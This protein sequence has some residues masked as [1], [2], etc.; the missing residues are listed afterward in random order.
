MGINK[1]VVN[2]E[3]K[4]DLTADTVSPST[5]ASGITA[6]DKSG[7][8]IVGTFDTAWAPTDNELK[9]I[10]NL[11]Y[12]DY[13]GKMDWFLTKYGNRIKFGWTTGN[14]G[15]PS[16]A[17][18]YYP[19]TDLSRT[20][21]SC[22]LETLPIEKIYWRLNHTNENPRFATDSLFQATFKNCVNLK[23]LPIFE[24]VSIGSSPLYSHYY[25]G[26][27]FE[28]CEQLREI[29]F[30]DQLPSNKNMGHIRHHYDDVFAYCYSL[31]T[32]PSL[33]FL[34]CPNPDYGELFLGCYALEA[35]NNLPLNNTASSNTTNSFYN[36]FSYCQRLKSL[37]F[38]CS[39]EY[40]WKNH[41][42]DLS[43]YVGYG[44][45]ADKFYNSGLTADG[46]VN[47]SSTYRSKKNTSTWW[48]SDMAYSRY[49]RTSAVETINSL[50]DTSAY[51]ASAG[52]TNTIKFKGAAGSATAGGAINTLTAEEI[53]VATAKGWTVSLVD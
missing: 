19:V 48:T 36:A 21:E 52:G 22:A 12:W 46:E 42:I 5:L 34:E 6:H 25:Y 43:N 11:A 37:T 16:T 15:D 14:T 38:T 53:A 39:G 47:S 7:E 30:L 26:A 27:M 33:T 28:S 9:F 4:L 41:T 1:V 45:S 3:V 20:F 2:D 49:N 29:P 18:V 51:L 23:T 35:I 10:G 50:P 13:L 32:I 44:Y 8:Q 31:R 17:W 40:S 24:K